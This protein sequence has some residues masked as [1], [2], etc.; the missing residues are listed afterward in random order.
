MDNKGTYKNC[1]GPWPIKEQQ[2]IKNGRHGIYL[3]VCLCVCALVNLPAFRSVYKNDG[4][5]TRKVS[6]SLKE[7]NFFRCPP[8]SPPLSP[9]SPP[10]P[11]LS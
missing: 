7:E 3:S 10:P 8:T 2:K 6:Q 4:G 1:L 5:T 9:P 11:L